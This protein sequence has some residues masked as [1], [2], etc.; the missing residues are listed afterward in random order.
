MLIN[1]PFK[2]REGEKKKELKQK[3]LNELMFSL[4]QLQM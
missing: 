2:E 3:K 1:K 4:R